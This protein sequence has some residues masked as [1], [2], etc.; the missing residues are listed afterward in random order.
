MREASLDD[1]RVRG[2]ATSAE[3]PGAHVGPSLD[4]LPGARGAGTKQR[5]I[6]VAGLGAAHVQ[7]RLIHFYAVTGCLLLGVAAMQ[8]S[9]ATRYRERHSV[10]VSLSPP[11]DAQTT[12][13]RPVHVLDR[14]CVLHRRSHKH[15]VARPN[16]VLAGGAGN[17]DSDDDDDTTNDLSVND[18]S[19][20]P[21]VSWCHESVCY[22]IDLEAR[23]KLP[24]PDIPSAP[25]PGFKRL[26][27]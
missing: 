22:V 13:E 9:V 18:D 21:A 14:P 3:A 16:S 7:L 24:T 27:C 2:I 6:K 26:R 5:T 17:D 4:L 11:I 23:S 8:S 15:L 10:D 25:F 19:D 20:V 1:N 12:T